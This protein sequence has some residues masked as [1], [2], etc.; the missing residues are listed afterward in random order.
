MSDDDELRKIR[1]TLVQILG[2]MRV[3]NEIARTKIAFEPRPIDSQGFSELLNAIN[4]IRL[5]H[6]P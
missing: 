1:A 4:A 6:E 3:A 5:E 2:E